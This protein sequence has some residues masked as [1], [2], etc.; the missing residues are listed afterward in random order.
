MKKHAKLD[1][2]LLQTTR[3]IPNTILKKC[4]L[5][6]GKWRHLL[7][8]PETL[9]SR[10]MNSVEMWLQLEQQNYLL[11]PWHCHNVILQCSYCQSICRSTW[12][13]WTLL[14][15][16]YLGGGGIKVLGFWRQKQEIYRK[17][18]DTTVI[19]LT[20][21][22]SESPDENTQTVAAW[23]FSTPLASATVWLYFAT[24]CTTWR[25][26]VWSCASRWLRP[27]ARAA[28]S[29][30]RRCSLMNH[31]ERN[32]QKL[33]GILFNFH[34]SARLAVHLTELKIVNVNYID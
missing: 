33:P 11:D 30:L 15:L 9:E 23:L 29:Q 19:F 13:T 25:R 31:H 18:S 2:L 21:D 6:Q 32:L 1:L 7:L 5:R 16:V 34:C 26:H 20:T 8:D 10:E 3:F 24:H 4:F 12:T 27:T 28:A 17:C 22:H 14:S